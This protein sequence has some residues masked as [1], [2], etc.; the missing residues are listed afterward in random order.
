MGDLIKFIIYVLGTIEL[1]S[2]IGRVLRVLFNA[3]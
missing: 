2:I 1:C 3:G